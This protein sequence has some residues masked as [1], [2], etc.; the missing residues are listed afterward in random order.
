MQSG[1]QSTSST[2]SGLR[3]G[4]TYYFTLTAQSAIGMSA[5]SSEVQA[6]IVPAAPTGLTATAG[7]GSVTLSWTG[8]SG[9]VSYSV[10]QSSSSGG[11]GAPPV[12]KAVSGTSTTVSNLIN[13]TTYYFKVNATNVGGNSV[14]SGQAQATPV[15]PA[16]GGG[17]SLGLEEL[18]LLA[19]A[20]GW[21]RRQAR[22]SLSERCRS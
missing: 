15:A 8:S 6:T 18:L 19:G 12:V 22:R 9:A 13:G 21:S 1:L 10:Y 20:L 16:G 5:P 11:E 2:L 14:L 4:T 17:G 3:Y 7:N